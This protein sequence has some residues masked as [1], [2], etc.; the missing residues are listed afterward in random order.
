MLRNS[1]VSGIQVDRDRIGFMIIRLEDRLQPNIGFTLRRI[2]ASEKCSIST[3][4]KSTTRFP[5]S[6]KMNLVRSHT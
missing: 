5:T 1:A 6:H 4:R 3:Y 2:L